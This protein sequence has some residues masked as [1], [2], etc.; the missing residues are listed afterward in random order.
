MKITGGVEIEGV[1]DVAGD[2]CRSST[3]LET[4]VHQFS[5]LQAHW[6]YGSAY[7]G[8]RY[9]LHL[10]KECLFRTLVCLKQ[11]RHQCKSRNASGR[12]PKLSEIISSTI[13]ALRTP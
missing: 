6:G 8:Q 13:I 9:E 4:A 7:D 5:I 10:C 2:V 12:P 11:E 3:R 1:L